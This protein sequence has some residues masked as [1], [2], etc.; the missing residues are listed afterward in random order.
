[1]PVHHHRPE[2]SRRAWPHR[3][4]RAAGLG[5]FFA[6]LA[7]LPQSGVGAS[8]GNTLSV[9]PTSGL[10]GASVT[11]SG[12]GWTVGVNP[13]YLIFWEAPGG[14]QLG[15]FSPG[16]GGNWSTGVTIPGGASPGGHAIVACE[17]Y[18]IEF[19]DCLSAPF[20]VVAPSPTPT[21]TP[22]GPP[23][24]TQTPRPSR[25]PTVTGLPTRTPTPTVEGCQ[26]AIGFLQPLEGSDLEG[27][28]TTDFVVD[29]IHR[30]GGEL[31]LRFNRVGYIVYTLWPDVV[32]GTT[33][34]MVE[35]PAS[36]GHYTMTI[37]DVPIV[38]GY[39]YWQVLLYETC[40]P[41]GVAL[42]SFYN[43]VAPT[44]TP[45][46]PAEFDVH[47]RAVE[48]TQGIRGDIPQ[49]TEDGDLVLRTD[50]AVHVAGRRTVVRVYPWMEI[51]R[52]GDRSGVLFTARLHGTRGGSP[53][54]G[55]PISPENRLVFQGRRPLEEMR[56]NA[57]TSW[58]FVLPA[59]WVREAGSLSLTIEV[60]PEGAEHVLECAGCD[61]NNVAYLSGIR[62]TEV[63]GIEVFPF[64]VRY[65][66]SRGVTTEPTLRQMVT[67]LDW[68]WRA[69]PLPD[70]GMYLHWPRVVSYS[71]PLD[72]FGAGS[73]PF[74]TWSQFTYMPCV[75]PRV[76]SPTEEGC[77][78]P[79]GTM[80]GFILPNEVVGCSGM[81]WY[82]WPWSESGSGCGPT[83]AQEF[84]HTVPLLHAGN[85]HGE[86]AGGGFD[87]AYPGPHGELEATAYGFDVVALRAIAPGSPTGGHT[88]DF[89]SYGGATQWVSL[90]TWQNL[91][92]FL[93]APTVRGTG[94]GGLLFAP[95]GAAPE[96][97]TSQA[98][99]LAGR[100]QAD[101]SITLAPAFLVQV[102]P[103]ALE[104]EGEGPYQLVL[105]NGTGDVLFTRNLDP[106]TGAHGPTGGSMFFADVPDS[107]D[108]ARID[109]LQDGRRIA[110][111]E[112]SEH[113]PT[114]RLLQPEG[115]E[116]WGAD[117]EV[118]VQW[119]GSDEDGDA[120]L[121]R[122]EVSGDEGETWHV[123]LGDVSATS[124]VLDLATV[125]V[126]GSAVRVRVQ[127]SD[128]LQSALGEGGTVDVAAKAPLPLIFR[129]SEGAVFRPEQTVDLLGQAA[130]AAEDRVAGSNLEWFLDGSPVGT[131]EQ[132]ALAAL[133]IGRHTVSL[134]ATNAAGL[135]GETIVSFDVT[136]D[137]DYDGL[138]DEWEASVGLDPL[139]PADAAADGD[140]DGLLNWEEFALGT[141]PQA[142]DSDGDGHDDRTE[143]VGGGDPADPTSLPGPIHGSEAQ[144]PPPQAQG[145]GA[146][147]SRLIVGVMIVGAVLIVLSALGLFLFMR[148]GRSSQS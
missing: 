77:Y 55:S 72:D 93:G 5:L 11:V 148:R 136:T 35:D 34:E 74:S 50:L 85:S 119:E 15:S 46:P 76:S 138:P 132:L 26:D 48:V 4:E 134:R 56:G 45:S 100:I 82:G 8:H 14:T 144:L 25:T 88:H 51:T 126:S 31:R 102:P 91:A 81:A 13:P 133:P 109:L 125:P 53:L 65:T 121:Y 62:F 18:G 142:R 9:N 97:A 141:N 28:P 59:S 106:L 115:G 101:G 96:Q 120:L 129:P 140:A 107:Q 23:T 147:P 44:R 92:R 71:G 10:A 123:V 41:R 124:A 68:L 113:A 61:R 128:G 73:F 36:A 94:G 54:P 24:S 112:A 67:Q 135:S 95:A 87:A 75:G 30:S 16:S 7:L 37:R 84:A 60:N 105:R 33:V 57:A 79:A 78:Y 103:G 146:Q 3:L 145:Q 89:M 43:G 69:W 1:M 116:I 108:L 17:G 137:T 143:V 139:D 110:R 127:A 49:R 70:F 90:Y 98:L 83:I 20:T 22:G 111:W 80:Y 122:L 99:R 114:V 66:D 131:G 64:L 40:L 47:A 38:L 12:T 58:N 104:A 21:H 117:G 63:N 39:N 2:T 29:I 27:V 86:A 32:A 118:Q 42:V 52:D 19:Q 130:D 6:A